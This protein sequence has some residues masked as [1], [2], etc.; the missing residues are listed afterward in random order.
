VADTGPAG[1]GFAGAM[2]L[3]FCVTEGFAV[4]TEAD[5]SP[6]GFW[7]VITSSLRTA[8]K[9]LHCLAEGN[10]LF[11]AHIIDKINATLYTLC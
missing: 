7:S 2:A 8:K 3:S 5:G 6:W 11:K 1:G 9:V 4:E 10:I